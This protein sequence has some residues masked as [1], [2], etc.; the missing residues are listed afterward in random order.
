[1]AKFCR[2]A[3]GVF[4]LLLCL[5]CLYGMLLPL[6][7]SAA[8]EKK[9]NQQCTSL[10]YYRNSRSSTVVGRMEH[11][12]ILKVLGT[13][14]SFYKIDCYDMYGYI[15]KDQVAINEKGEYYVNCKTGHQDTVLTKTVSSAEA[16]K[17]RLSLVSLAKKQVG[18]PYVY[19]GSKP[20]GFDCSG[21][22]QYLYNKQG[23]SLQRRSTL[24]L[25]NGIIIPK[26]QIRPGDLVFFRVPGD[27]TLTSHVGIYIGNGQIIHAGSKGVGYARLN[28][29]W[30]KDYY[31]CVRRMI[32]VDAATAE[33]LA[34]N[35]LS[36]VSLLGTQ[37]C[38]FRNSHSAIME[39][40]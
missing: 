11:G 7:V 32:P 39:I 21:L 33:A 16:L 10:V 2:L 18:Y 26:D 4:S 5:V 40:Q 12:T 27:S 3:L 20:G 15:A 17:M 37:Q 1:M 13:S 31:L 30:F 34:D 14:G 24:Q 36:G 23:I 22:M 25:M 35:L 9:D 8:E 38:V 6:R 29:Y 28:G 19:G